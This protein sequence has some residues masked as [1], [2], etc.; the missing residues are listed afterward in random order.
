MGGPQSLQRGGG[1]VLGGRGWGGQGPGG[2]WGSG[3]LKPQREGY[4]G[5]PAYHQATTT[6]CGEDYRSLITVAMSPLPFG[7]V[8]PGWR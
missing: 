1:G 6:C 7:P 5:Q 8:D 4:P 2:G 3:G